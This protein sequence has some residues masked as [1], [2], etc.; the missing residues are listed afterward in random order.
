MIGYWKFE[1]LEPTGPVV[2]CGDRS[3][4]M[5]YLDA[6]SSGGGVKVSL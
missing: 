3:L 6:K 4:E 1:K 5:G 2:P